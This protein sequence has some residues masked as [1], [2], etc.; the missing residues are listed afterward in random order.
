SG[1]DGVPA[2]VDSVRVADGLVAAEEV[3][4]QPVVRDLD[5]S[6]VPLDGADLAGYPRVA[7]WLRPCGDRQGRPR[8]GAPAVASALA[9]VLD[10]LRELVN[11]HPVR[12][13]DDQLAVATDGR[14]L[15]D[16]PAGRGR[17]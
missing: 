8:R 2:R 15:D 5:R 17:R 16:R 6:I 7:R 10:V 12:A 3:E 11:G 9:A 1:L 4:R 13:G 14:D